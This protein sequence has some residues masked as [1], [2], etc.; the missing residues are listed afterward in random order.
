[1]RLVLLVLVLLLFAS[2]G[3]ASK[4]WGNT[5]DPPCKSRDDK[6]KKDGS[7][8]DR[9]EVLMCH[10][11]TDTC[12]DRIDVD[13]CLDAGHTLGTCNS[14]HTPAPTPAPTLS[15]TPAP[16]PTPTPAPTPSLTPAPT[17]ATTT[18]SPTPAPVPA[19]TPSL[20]FG[21]CCVD[22]GCANTDPDS[23]ARV[24]GVFLG[25]EN[26]CDDSSCG[27]I[28][29][30]AC[31]MP[32][33]SCQVWI[34]ATICALEGGVYQSD[35]T[36]CFQAQCPVPVPPCNHTVV[37]TNV[38]GSASGLV[39]EPNGDI[40][41]GYQVAM[42]ELH[43]PTS[44]TVTNVSISLTI[45]C[46]NNGSIVTFSTNLPSSGFFIQ[47]DDQSFHPPD[48]ITNEFGPFSIG[49][50]CG[51]PFDDFVVLNA[52]FIAIVDA[53]DTSDTVDVRFNY[54][55]ALLSAVIVSNV[56]SIVPGCPDD[57]FPVSTATAPQ[58][59]PPASPTAVQ[60]L[61]PLNHTLVVPFIDCVHNFENGSC[62]VIF[63]Y[64]SPDEDAL[65]L[66]AGSGDNF[67]DPPPVIRDNMPSSFLPGIQGHV[68]SVIWPCLPS[69]ASIYD[70]FT[71][72]LPGGN[73]TTT[74]FEHNNC[75]VGCDDVPF[76]NAVD[77]VCGVCDGDGSFCAKIESC[78]LLGTNVTAGAPTTCSGGH[79][80][81]VQYNTGI[82]GGGTTAF[83]GVLVGNV[84]VVFQAFQLAIYDNDPVTNLPGSLIANT[85][86]GFLTANTIN[87]LPINATLFAA[88]NYWLS[89]TT[90]AT[91][92]SVKNVFIDPTG[93]S[94]IRLVTQ[95]TFAQF[96]DPFD[97]QDL[98]T[99][100]G[101]VTMF[102]SFLDCDPAC[103]TSGPF[104]KSNIAGANSEDISTG[105]L[106]HGSEFVTN[107]LAGMV[108]SMTLYIDQFICPPSTNVSF[109]M[110][111]YHDNNP[112]LQ[113]FMASTV[114]GG[115]T[116]AGFQTLPM[117]GHVVL[118]ADT[119]YYLLANFAPS[120]CSTITFISETG[121]VN[122]MG[123]EVSNILFGDIPSLLPP[124]RILNNEDH[125]IYASFAP[126]CGELFSFTPHV[127]NCGQQ[128]GVITGANFIEEFACASEFVLFS[129]FTTDPVTGFG[130]LL[131]LSIFVG[132][133]DPTPANDLF[134][135]TIYDSDFVTGLPNNLLGQT[136]GLD[137][138]LPFQWNDALLIAP[139][140]VFPAS[141]YWI[142]FSSSAFTCNHYNDPYFLS[143]VNRLGSVSIQLP[144]ANFV[145]G[146]YP[147]V[148]P[149][150]SATLLN[151]TYA[152]HANYEC[153]GACCLST[154]CTSQ[155]RTDCNA[156]GGVFSSS[157][158]SC[159]DFD[160]TE[161]GHACCIGGCVCG[162]FANIDICTTLNNGV[163]LG[164]NVS[165]AD[166][167]CPLTG[168]CCID[169]VC[170]S[171]S[172]AACTNSG[173][174]Y[175]GDGSICS[176]SDSCI[177]AGH[178]CCFVDSECG[179]LNRTSCLQN[180]GMYLGD[181][182][183]CNNITCPVPTTPPPGPPPH[184]TTYV[185]AILVPVLVISLLCICCFGFLGFG[186]VR[187]RRRRTV[188]REE[189]SVTE[190]LIQ[191]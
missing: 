143:L 90:D 112:L 42:P 31:C 93:S 156:N 39:I 150:G 20:V 30:H 109:Q 107:G 36:N 96:P 32:D 164:D 8:D 28:G 166:A 117:N 159:I 188:T 180:G 157:G 103:P 41:F 123:V 154:V 64:V 114:V 51:L 26:I 16:T 59:T 70:T 106:L 99:T 162:V 175:N 110:Y 11:H 83:I 108:I 66:A 2:L 151:R 173:G 122:T 74:S 75:P 181:F 35:I 4:R 184:A 138:L 187:R 34:N 40:F 23:C 80:T 79:I 55:N 63:G 178:A 146:S 97:I 27:A 67:F 100:I 132:P 163:Y 69:Y 43:P 137:A 57:P 144:N 121:G 101:T 65:F 116:S 115:I 134:F 169:A 48:N 15:P 168:A 17:P 113:S 24:N 182:V 33:G 52:T 7:E 29:Q 124:S 86:V 14:T 127:T 78:A 84:D 125:V 119:S 179:V 191:T 111:I 102:V 136:S 18:A 82:P 172:N 142:S 185:V 153:E 105:N 49:N 62:Y 183:S 140:E 56:S 12:V 1:M 60:E 13:A 161:V 171:L 50:P 174:V 73:T 149:Q 145:F 104:G 37:T 158:T 45:F 91:D 147:S 10:N 85:A 94:V 155:L 118:V 6:H 47:Q 167:T 81:N 139:V 189:Y 130:T 58:F 5:H 133:I 177:E 44:G 77:D 61:E 176:S 98:T 19:T 22:T 87:Q 160:C 68:F 141:Q 152:M 88:T 53:N 126:S 129:N 148:F 76:S 165:C 190:S 92:C 120:S 95:T 131:S 72:A 3:R 135:M 71:W 170:V 46:N 186:S 89:Y 54:G 38:T 21:A 25:S 128:F 9:D